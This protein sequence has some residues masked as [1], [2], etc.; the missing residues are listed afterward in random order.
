MGDG[1]TL[2]VPSTYTLAVTGT[3][4][5]GTGEIAITNNQQG[6]IVASLAQLLDFGPGVYTKTSSAAT[7]TIDIYGRVIGFTTPDTFYYTMTAYTASSGQTVFS[8]T[9]A[10]GYIPG[11][12]FVFRNGL[13]LDTSN[14]TDAATTVT[15]AN[16]ATIN[17]IVTIISMASVHAPSSDW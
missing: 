1:T 8:V 10:S 3:T 15:L 5:V 2:D 13:L 4:T 16:G 14:Y 12:C 9:R 6:Q 7:L 17:D 11:Q